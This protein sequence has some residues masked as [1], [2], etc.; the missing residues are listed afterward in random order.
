MVLGYNMTN[1][2]AAFNFLCAKSEDSTEEVKIIYN[3]GL[4]LT[5]TKV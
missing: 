4:H 1:R 5:E 3:K 2:Q